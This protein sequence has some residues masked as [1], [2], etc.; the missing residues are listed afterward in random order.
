MANFSRKF[1]IL[2]KDYFSPIISIQHC[3]DN[4]SFDSEQ[5]ALD[6][7]LSQKRLTPIVKSMLKVVEVPLTQLWRYENTYHPMQL[8]PRHTRCIF[9]KEKCLLITNLKKFV[10]PLTDPQDFD[11]ITFCLIGDE[12]NTIHNKPFF[13]RLRTDALSYEECPYVSPADA[14]N[15]SGETY[16]ILSYVQNYGYYTTTRKGET[17]IPTRFLIPHPLLAPNV[18]TGVAEQRFLL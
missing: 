1:V 7:L 18:E 14:L 13:K 6:Y 11:I 10:S 17:T 5:E 9:D 2:S 16:T 8:I 4:T 3:L 12:Y 15:I